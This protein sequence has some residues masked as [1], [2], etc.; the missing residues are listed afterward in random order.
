M[1]K[2]ECHF[3]SAKGEVI[4]QIDRNGP[5]V[6][7]YVNPNDDPA[8]K[9][10]GREPFV[11]SAGDRL[12]GLP[13]P[14]VGLSPSAVSWSSDNIGEYSPSRSRVHHTPSARHAARSEKR[15]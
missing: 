15:Y 5:F 14:S 13:V 11:I 12:Y 3:A 2:Q 6:V 9:N 4:V 10:T 8:K 1:P 7:N